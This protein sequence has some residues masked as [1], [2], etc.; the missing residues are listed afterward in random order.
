[1]TLCDPSAEGDRLSG[2]VPKG[3]AGDKINIL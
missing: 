1:L 2:V 3:G